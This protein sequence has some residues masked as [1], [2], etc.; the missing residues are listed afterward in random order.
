MMNKDR[1]KRLIREL[2]AEI[3]EDPTREGLVDTPSR[4]ADMYEE[5][6][7]GYD[8]ESELTVK[9]SEDSDMV[10]AR[11]IQF[12]SMCE[13]HML[14][15]F[16]KITIAYSPDGKVFGIS[17]LVRLVEKY[18]TRLQIQERITKNIADELYS[19]G[20]KGVVVI[21]EGE[22]LCMKMRGVRN[23][24]VVTT[25]ASRGIY[26]KKE[27]RQDVLSLIYNGRSASNIA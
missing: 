7:K 13:H 25:L 4:I 17:K 20:V 12:Y 19:E 5:I 3:G 9:F 18:S 10:V 24:A 26:E 23:D 21:A 11:D 6:F 27:A 2:I 16:G 15:F 22:H 8:A 1:V 14:P